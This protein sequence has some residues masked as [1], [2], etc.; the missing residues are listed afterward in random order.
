MSIDPNL[1]RICLIYYNKAMELMQKIQE[2]VEDFCQANNIRLGNW[3]PSYEPIYQVEGV[4]FPMVWEARKG[5][6][7]G[8][9]IVNW[10]GTIEWFTPEER[11]S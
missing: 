6:T 3:I 10:D 4:D 1:I 5:D 7:K 9:V 2:K 8:Y 11:I